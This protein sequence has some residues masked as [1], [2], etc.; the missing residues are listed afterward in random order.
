MLPNYIRIYVRGIVRNED[1]ILVQSVAW[2]TKDERI[3][4]LLG[5]SIKYG[6]YGKDA[7]TREFKE[8]LDT[9]IENVRYIG[10]I[11]NIFEKS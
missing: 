9:D 5:G 6:E 2:L 3:Y 11:E 1:K 8:E 7:I 10:M 4:I